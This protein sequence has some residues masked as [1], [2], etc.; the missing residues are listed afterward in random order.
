M[1]GKGEGLGLCQYGA[2]S[3]AKSGK[4]AEE[5]LKY[6][7]T[8]VE[9]KN[10]DKPSINKPLTG[11]IIVLDPG[12][13]GINTE[14]VY[15]PTGLRE[16]DVNLCISLK[17]AQ[18]LRGLGAKVYETR[19]EDVYVPL[20]KRAKLAE[21]VRPDFFI[22]IHQNSFLNSNI[23]GSE[24]Y[25]YR[26]DEEGEILGNLILEEIH[27]KVGLIKR[28]TKIAEFYLLREVKSSVLHIEVGF[29]TN[30]EEEKKLRE[31]KTQDKIA[32]AMATGLIRFYSYG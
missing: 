2:N 24:V 7:F 15:G 10:F 32:E 9:I 26:G 6:Y 14:D 1:Q 29:I 28:G 8:G 12:H 18:K 19:K 31:E 20:G 3:M 5:I 17:L 23:S 16:K 30:P 21:E 22:S 11:R 25:H 27:K 13:G 4:S